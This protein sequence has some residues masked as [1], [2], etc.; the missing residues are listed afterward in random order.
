MYRNS[1]HRI[2]GNTKPIFCEWKGYLDKLSLEFM[3]YWVVTFHKMLNNCSNLV[4]VRQRCARGVRP[5]PPCRRKFWKPPPPVRRS[6]TPPPLATQGAA[7]F[8]RFFWCQ[9][10]FSEL[11]VTYRPLSTIIEVILSLSTYY[12]KMHSIFKITRIRIVYI[13]YQLSNK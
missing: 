11:K 3:G 10:L 8:F 13:D 12:F 9:R 4:G 1:W 6:R 5:K 2:S 7:K